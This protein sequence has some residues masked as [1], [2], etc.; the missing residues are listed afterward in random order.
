[1][2]YKPVVITQTEQ[3]RKMANEKQVGRE[4]FQS[5]LLDNGKMSRVLDAIRDG[6]R[7]MIGAPLVVPPGCRI[8]RVTVEVQLDQ[9]WQ[10]AVNAAGP[11]TPETHN[12]R[13]VGDL[14]LPTGTDVVK[15]ELIL[16]NYAKGDGNWD[17]ALAWADQFR[18][19]K[20]DPRRVFAIGKARPN[21]NTEVGINPTYVV[22]TKECSFGDYRRA[23]S[24][25]WNVSKREASLVWVSRY[26]NADAW[27]AFRE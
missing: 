7:I 16:L 19:R 4:H 10:A 24:V 21:F 11:N 17:K 12:V 25:W 23:C 18:L 5:D 27:F 6:G 22:A 15:E 14:Y 2:S 3:I 13:K 8:E 20:T 1:M 9:G 26:G